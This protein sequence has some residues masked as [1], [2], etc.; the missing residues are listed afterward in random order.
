MDATPATLSR[1]DKL[2]RIIEAGAD[3]RALVLETAKAV[4]AETAAG[5]EDQFMNGMP[6]L[7]AM[8]ARADAVDAVLRAILDHASTKVFPAANPTMGERFAVIAVGGYGRG[9]L[10]PY[11]DIDLLFL[12]H[13]KRTSRVEQMVE[14]VLYLMWDMGLKVGHA[15]RTVSDCMRLAKND[16]TIRTSMLEDRLIWGDTAL[17]VD[18]RA[19]FWKELGS[20][21]AHFMAA[22]LEEREGRH[23]SY[24][25]SRYLLEPNVKEG[26]GGIRDLHALYWIAK[27]HYQVTEVSELVDL[28]VFTRG[29]RRRFRQA[30]DFLM[31]V[32]CHL[33]HW[34]GRAEERLTFDAQVA[35]AERMGYADR[36]HIRGVERFMKHY[37]L[38]AKTVGDMTRILC[39]A[40]EAE[41]KKPSRFSLGRLLQQDRELEGF[42]LTG[43]RLAVKDDDA[44]R[45]NPVDMLRIFNVA[46]RDDLDIH[47]G[48]LRLIR[49]DLK[50]I[51]AVR[52]DPEAN[53]LFLEMLTSKKTPARALS[54]LNEAALL[55]RFVPDF[56]RVVALMQYDMYHTYTV[57]EHTIRAIGM[58]RALE[59]GELKDEAPVATRVLQRVESRRALYAAVFMHDIAKGRGGDHSILGAAVA[60][61]LCPRLGLDP[62]E[63]ETVA[64]LVRHHLV[65]SRTA[66]KRDPADPQ[67]VRD[68]V[69]VVQ[70]LER[71]RLLLA[72]TVCDIRAVGPNTWTEWKASLLRDLY[73]R[74]EEAIAGGDV[75]RSVSRRIAQVRE[76]TGE[77]LTSWTPEARD[78][79]LEHAPDGFWLSA[80]PA[81]L[82]RRLEV[83]ARA[84]TAEPPLV[85]EVTPAP[86]GD[87]TEVIVATPDHPGLFAR[88]AGG[89][90]LAGVDIVQSQATTFSDGLVLDVFSVAGD[91]DDDHV[92]HRLDR[93][94]GCVER[95]LAGKV[96]LSKELTKAPPWRR[97]SEAFSVTPQV[98]MDNKASATHT[99]IEVCGRDRL[100]FLNKI[101]WTLTQQGLQ[102]SQSRIA[103]YGERAVDVF[104]VK[105]V[106]GL[107]VE[108]EGKIASVRRA[109]FQ[110]LEELDESAA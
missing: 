35:I 60:Q 65:M 72:L 110:A 41:Q 22:K 46:E 3:D 81:E 105:D 53:R 23:A 1:Q 14:H 76:A 37:Y 13:Y 18:L 58:L 96:S 80:P 90:A 97:R 95:A 45:A 74:A 29:E 17:E 33:H 11:S 98:I 78:A 32:R 57:D 28:G 102:I 21:D 42:E 2:A 27:H 34:A 6:A 71:L 12:T 64:W 107:K 56:G 19:A 49:R 39:A 87:A 15:T 108:Q 99:V 25:D 94:R 67:T 26:K 91:P 77:E 55:G 30:A 16:M 48:A 62:S 109:L 101:A 43:G 79:A 38:T 59:A 7:E 103:T 47:P 5:L 31:T 73:Y 9:H 40:L 70:S 68:F 63:T 84:K 66:V 89:L 50:K 24:G 88:I 4:L 54:R 36:P 52:E 100:G 8:E 83:Y 92:S 85:I 82:A 75:G 93:I 86:E 51:D 10:A 104:Y 61:E 44:F 69:D 20:D 106:F